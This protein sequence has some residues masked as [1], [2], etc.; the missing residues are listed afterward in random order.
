MPS[1]H[2][3]PTVLDAD[4]T[5]LLDLLT[6]E[7]SA[8]EQAADAVSYGSAEHDAL[9]KLAERRRHVLEPLVLYWS[10]LT[11]SEA[12]DPRQGGPHYELYVRAVLQSDEKSGASLWLFGEQVEMVFESALKNDGLSSDQRISLARAWESYSKDRKRVRTLHGVPADLEDEGDVGIFAALMSAIQ[13]A[14][15]G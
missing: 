4:I 11:T 15:T 13:P 5:L 14:P 2:H 6:G 7:V 10:H 12:S 9:I 3:K 8:I 1:L